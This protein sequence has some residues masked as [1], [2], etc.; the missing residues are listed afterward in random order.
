M[1]TKSTNIERKALSRVEAHE[2]QSWTSIAFIWIGTM[3]CIPMLMVGGI[4][5]TA[6]TLGNIA[7]AAFLGFAICCIIMV[8]TGMQG[9]DLGLPCTMCATKAFGDR[10]AS[11]LMSVVIFIAQ[12][13]WFGVQTATCATAFN[14]LLQ[15]WGVAFPFWISCVIWGAVML[16]TAVYG[17]KF[18]KI[19]NYI[20]V[21]ALLIMCG[22]GAIF[23]INM[24][25]FDNLSS[26]VPAATMPL[27]M[28]IS[29]VIGLFAVGTVIN[30]DYSRYAKKRGDTVK[31]TVI[32]VL[33]A[34]VIMI[35]IGAV[36]ALAAGNY[37]ITAVFA[38]L[39]LP[40]VSMLVLI[41]ATWTTNTG[42]AYTAGLAAMKIFSFKDERRPLVTLVCGGIG[43]LV[44][45]AGL[46]SVLE[47]FISILSSLVPP[48]AGVMIADYWIIGRG[49]PE[50]WHP[51]RGF[52]WN[53]IV[54]W[55]A[56]ATVS[57]FFSFFSPA[58]DG[59]A[60]CCVVYLIL[61]ALFGKTAMAGQTLAETQAQID[62]N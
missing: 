16:V 53:G 34:A 25:G 8:L 15:Y 30:A 11:L 40:V 50:N 56:G 44:A 31:A 46:A 26:Y 36:M 48:I 20:A 7:L 5:S 14:T 43:T 1:E 19:L 41:L 35:L 24:A 51:V 42:N 62:A 38:S 3:I 54:S 61:N 6:M 57:L 45:I 58:L 37:D 39:G 32:G 12:L 28:G 27:S 29:I 4:F 2:R 60:V 22:Y 55:A 9:T 17:F 49:K 23:A 21:P 47:S 33:P 18:M 59:I 10:G 52:N 13:G